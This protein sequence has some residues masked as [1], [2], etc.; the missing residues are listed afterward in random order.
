MGGR[1]GWPGPGCTGLQFD[2]LGPFF[3]S[4][5]E[6]V[7]KNLG[8]VQ[9][10]LGEAQQKIQLGDLERSHTGGG[11]QTGTL[12]VRQKSEKHAVLL[13]HAVIRSCSRSP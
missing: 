7:Q 5:Y 3:Q 13:F 2:T 12:G 11:K 6:Q 8:E 1:G 10:Q 9:K 4:K